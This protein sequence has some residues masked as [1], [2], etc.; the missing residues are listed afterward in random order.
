MSKINW[1]TPL[2][3]NQN[4]YDGSKFSLHFLIL[5]ASIGIV[6]GATHVFAPDRGAGIIAGFKL[7]EVKEYG[8]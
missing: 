1:K 8:H 7:D 5:W 3:E 2:P 4:N 6:R